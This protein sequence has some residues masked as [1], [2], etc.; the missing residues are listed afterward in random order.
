MDLIRELELFSEENK[1]SYTKIARAINVGISTLSMWRNGNYNGDVEVIDEKIR[2]FLDRQQKKMRRIDFSAE[3]DTKKKVYFVLDTIKR[4]VA[5]NVSEQ[6]IESAKIGYIFGRAGVGKTHALME[7]VKEYKGRSLFITA[8]NGISS[9]GLI[10][11]IARE[12]R[13]DLQGTADV[14]KERIKDT[15]RF[16]E[17]VIII[18]EGEHL[19]ASVIDIV[20]S[21]ADQTGVG[22]VIAGTEALKSKVFSQNKEYE[23][24]YSRA[25][26]NMTLKDLGIED[27]GNIVRGFLKNEVDLYKEAELQEL[28]AFINLQVRG[29]A[30]QLS[31]LLTTAGQIATENGEAKITKDFVKAAVTTLSIAL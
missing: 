23:Y 15:L 28:I 13:V 5:S 14:L 10:R 16:T 22:V 30:R 26:V 11:K 19:K 1:M 18:D 6:I 2:D 31:N 8:E 24:L 3:T 17:T 21:I 7:W 9:V 27:V 12:L 29:S 20:R 25:V 4:Y